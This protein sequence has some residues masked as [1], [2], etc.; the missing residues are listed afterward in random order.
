MSVLIELHKVNIRYR[1]NQAGIHSVKDFFTSWANPFQ[2]TSILKDIS[3]RLEKGK[4]LGI[5]GRN[6]C[7]KSTLLRAVAG[8]IKPSSGQCI[9]RG[10]VA[11]ILALGAGLELELSGYE[12]IRLLLALYG[13]KASQEAID[14]IVQFSELDEDTLHQA[15]KCYSSGMLARLTFSISFSQDCDLY[16]ID[17]VMAVGDMGFQGKCKSRIRELQE[18]GKSFLFVSHFPDEVEKI[19]E[20]AI[21]L[22]EGRLIQQ[23]SATEICQQYRNLFM[24]TK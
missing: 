10:T 18:A 14:A 6:G 11:P 3:L 19:C 16:I 4:S 8:I 24:E 2:T 9:C 12:N 21:L 15:V 17:E 13:K 1:T 5:L 22:D 23:G 20:Q 7:G